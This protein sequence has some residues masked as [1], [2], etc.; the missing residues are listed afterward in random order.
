MYVEISKIAHNR[1]DATRNICANIKNRI[2]NL[3]HDLYI[4]ILT[5]ISNK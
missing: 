2:G 1:M 5:K 4:I 3:Y